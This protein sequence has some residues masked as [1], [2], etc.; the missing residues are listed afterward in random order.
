MGRKGRRR[1]RR[2]LDEVAR[3]RPEIESPEDAIRRGAIAVDGRVNMNP[4]SLVREGASIA[5]QAEAPLRGEA[6]LSAAL[7]AFGLDVTRRVALDV[8][9]AAGGFTCVLLEAG[10]RRVYAV[11]A[12]H[13]QLLGSLRQDLRVVNLEATNLAELTVQLVPDA[14]D[15]VTIDVSYLALAAAVPQLEGIQIAATADA[16]ALVKPQFELG[17]ERPPTDVAR[18]AEAVARARAG[19][20]AAG[21]TV[22]GVIDSP[23][24][25][26]RG[27]VEFLLHARRYDRSECP[28]PRPRPTSPT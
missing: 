2:L 8:G 13:G 18:L 28:S 1:L 6:K 19:F 20:E 22:G 16:I 3:Q 5:L 11:D 26:S 14:I 9:A 23:V 4:V 27:A 25:G 15:I 21:W 12:G 17:L 7:E 10:A 24:R